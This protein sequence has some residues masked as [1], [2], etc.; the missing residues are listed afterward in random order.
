MK[1]KYVSRET[2]KIMYGFMIEI[3]NVDTLPKCFT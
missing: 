1:I 2:C 3:I